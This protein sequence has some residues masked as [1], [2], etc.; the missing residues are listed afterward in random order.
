M[1]LAVRTRRTHPGAPA[2]TVAWR[3]V[4]AWTGVFAPLVQAA[5]AATGLSG[6]RWPPRMRGRSAHPSRSTTAYQVTTTG[7]SSSGT[8][9]GSPS[10]TRTSSEVQNRSCPARHSAADV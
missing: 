5:F 8:K 3:R 2:R 4:L 6:W 10:S 1:V 7:S 9:V